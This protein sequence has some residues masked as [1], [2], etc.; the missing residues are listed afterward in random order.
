VYPFFQNSFAKIATLW[1]GEQERTTAATIGAMAY[2]GGTLLGLTIG[3]FFVLDSDE[4]PENHER[5]KDH[6]RLLM[7]VTALLVTAICLPTL[8]VFRRAPKVFP[9]PS[10]EQAAHK[11]KEK[12]TE[13]LDTT[14][15]EIAVS[16]W[17]EFK[18][19]MCNT[20]FILLMLSFSMQTTG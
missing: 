5:G 4:L 17:V 15:E 18:T 11:L 3:P 20:N 1:F 2:G 14:I 13:D 8:F 10:A 19:L 7:F 12:A 6:V 9:S 16:N